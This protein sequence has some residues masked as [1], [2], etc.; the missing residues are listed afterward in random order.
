MLILNFLWKSLD[1]SPSCRANHEMIVFFLFFYHCLDILIDLIDRQS[2]FSVSL[3][4]WWSL[5]FSLDLFVCLFSPPPSLSSFFPSSSPPSSWK[6]SSLV[7]LCLFQRSVS[8]IVDSFSRNRS[9]SPLSHSPSSLLVPVSSSLLTWSIIVTPFLRMI[10]R[11]FN[12]LSFFQLPDV[13]PT[14]CRSFNCCLSLSLSSLAWLI[15]PDWQNILILIP[16]IFLCH[17]WERVNWIVFFPYT[18]TD[19]SYP[20]LLSV[21]LSV[22]MYVCM[23]VSKYVYI[24]I[25]M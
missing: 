10:W 15:L 19:L 16:L 1:L 25:C 13:H 18:P 14:A 3:P 22:Y 24:Y 8:R 6:L 7:V 5:C 12:C 17:Q 9:S 20:S 23:S 11:S 4:T 2:L 21:C